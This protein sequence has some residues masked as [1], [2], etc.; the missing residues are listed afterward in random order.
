M[1]IPWHKVMARAIGSDDTPID[2]DAETL[3]I[4]AL[5][6]DEPDLQSI[7]GKLTTLDPRDLRAVRKYIEMLKS[8]D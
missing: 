4:A 6:T 2:T 1:G 7:M 5:I 3:R 8:G